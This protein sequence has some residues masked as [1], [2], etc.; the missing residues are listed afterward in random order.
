M[1][2]VLFTME[3]LEQAATN[4]VVYV[5]CPYCEEEVAVEPGGREACCIECGEMFRIVNLFF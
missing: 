3:H 2:S 5:T 4:T 1:K